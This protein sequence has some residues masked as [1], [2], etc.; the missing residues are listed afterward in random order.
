ME[1]KTL[2][3]TTFGEFMRE[4]LEKVERI[5]ALTLDEVSEE[6]LRVIADNG[7]VYIGGTGHSMALMLEGFYRAGGLACVQPLYHPAL[8]PLHGGADST[9]FEH[10]PD[11]A[12]LLV[13][14][15]A[16]SAM[17]LSFVISNSGVNVVPVELAEQLQARGTPVVAMVSLV[18]LRTALARTTHKLDEVADFILDTQVPYGDAAY[19]V[20]GSATAGLSSL[21]NVFLW[22]LIL[23]RVADRAAGK[24]IRLPLWTSSNVEGGAE[25]NAQLKAAYRRRIPLL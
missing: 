10:T 3:S 2:G 24:G 19:R 1:T 9:L 4:H 11:V 12:R 21:T 6:M 25:R 16:P 17:D 7:L 8:L 22:N 13:E 23:T 20:D 14:R 18:H 5:N 15:Y